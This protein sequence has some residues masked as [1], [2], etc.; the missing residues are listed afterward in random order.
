MRSVRILVLVV[1]A[2]VCVVAAPPQQ[3]IKLLVH[4]NANLRASASTQSQRSEITSNRTTCPGFCRR[5]RTG[6]GKFVRPP[7]WKDRS[8]KR[9]CTSSSPMTCH[10]RRLIRQRV[11]LVN[12]RDGGID[13]VACP[14]GATYPFLLAVQVKHHLRASR[15]TSSSDVRDFLGAVATGRFMRGCL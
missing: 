8:P 6:S 12:E 1:V 3:E 5:R 15:K 9:S 10:Q 4:H 13:I 2:S 11:G 7:A 14:S